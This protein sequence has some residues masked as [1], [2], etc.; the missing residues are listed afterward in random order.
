MSDLGNS[1]ESP[2]VLLWD[3][4]TS[5]IVGYAWDKWNTNLL[6]IEQDRFLLTIAWKWLGETKVHCLGLPDFPERYA[7][8]P[9][10]D[11]EL[12]KLAYELFDLA[13]VVVAHNGVAFDTKKAQARMIAH[14]FGPPSP[15][16]EIDTLR[17]ARSH[18]SFTSNKLGD[19]C[20]VLGIGSKL[21]PGGIETWF[22]CIAGDPHAWRRMKKYN[23]QDV[24]ILE[25]LY[26][27]LRPWA[28]RLPNLA[29]IGDRPGACPKCGVEGKMVSRGWT[30]TAVTKRRQYRCGGCGGY[31]SGRK[32]IKS[33]T[34]FVNA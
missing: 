28:N 30:T 22:Q 15:F 34:E 25:K 21:D 16:K 26:I 9:T 17:I 1:G 32:I 7:K 18:F 4:E 31:V 20:A 2:R 5:P 8:D 13:D 10:D 23:K 33:E 11:Y 24:V 27:K 12:A 3:I 19:V 29:N 6:R 14:G